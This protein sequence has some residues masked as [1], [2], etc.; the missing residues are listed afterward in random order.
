[1]S[2]DLLRESRYGNTATIDTGTTAA[3]ASV[4]SQSPLRPRTGASLCLAGAAIGA[5]GLPGWVVGAPWLTTFVP[6]LPPMMPNT[7]ASLLLVGAAAAARQSAAIRRGRLV[8]S[9]VGV[10]TVLA[11]AVTTL[12]EYVLGIHLRVLGVGD[13]V[14]WTPAYVAPGRSSPLTAVALGVVSFIVLVLMA[15]PLNRVHRAVQASRAELRSFVEDAPDGIF[16][17]DLDG[18]Y[19]DVNEAGCRLLGCSREEI[20]GRTIL[21]LIPPADAERLARSK[22]SLLG[23][24]VQV[25]EWLLRRKDGSYVPVEVSAKILADGRWQGFVRD[26]SERKR[27]QREA[28]S[29]SEQLRALTEELRLSEARATGILAISADAIISIDE[30]QRITQFNDGAR[31]IFGY[32]QREAIGAPLEM[33]MPE[34]FR[35]AHRSHVTRFAGESRAARRMGTRDVPIVGLRKNGEEFPADAAI[36][37]LEVGGK[38]ILTVVVRDVTEQKRIENE[39]R[40][41]YEEARRAMKVRDEVLSIVAHDLRNPL[42]AI[43]IETQILEAGARQ[44]ERRAQPPGEQIRRA[45]K[46]MNALIQDLLDVTRLEAGALTL[47]LRRLPAAQIVADAVDSQAA[48]AA[49]ASLELRSEV[50]PGLP[51]LAGDRDRLRQVFENLIGNAIKFTPPGGCITVSAVRQAACVRFAVGDTGPGIAVEDQPHLF[52]RF[53]QGRERRHGAGLGLPIVKGIVEA[54]GGRVWIDSPP[55]LGTSVFFTIPIA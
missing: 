32:S 25:D 40:L 4:R 38:R 21:D 28:D 5:V 48:L 3:V 22:A 26:I 33:L 45:A 16:V 30:T 36:S 2:A 19:T 1:V 20:V 41:L 52:D 53:W 44:P 6:G 9:T 29:A 27:F 34:R 47:D 17:A 13:V 31:T 55:G 14:A 42:S 18:R 39:Q 43:L 23:G 7:A 50:S 35:A 37:R 8:L 12:L 11:I 54:H 24:S 46:R 10:L 49:R 51:E 15:L